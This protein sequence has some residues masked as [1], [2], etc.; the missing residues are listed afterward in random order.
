MK[1]TKTQ[2][3][4]AID[5]EQ[6]WSDYLAS[7]R[8]A[9][10]ADLGIDYQSDKWREKLRDDEESPQCKNLEEF[11]RALSD[12]EFRELKVFMWIGRGEHKPAEFQEI[13]EDT[14]MA[15][16]RDEDVL[17]MIEKMEAANYLRD[18]FEKLNAARII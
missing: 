14:S 13:Y 6:A 7:T 17:Y 9:A 12:A 16:D 5:L 10:E 15:T 8:T 18:G 11:L 3:E 2:V 1:L 4:K